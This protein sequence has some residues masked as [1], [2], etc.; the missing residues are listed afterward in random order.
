[1][2]FASDDDVRFKRINRITSAFNAPQVLFQLALLGA[3]FL[4]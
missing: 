1:V 4:Q 3:G 2:W